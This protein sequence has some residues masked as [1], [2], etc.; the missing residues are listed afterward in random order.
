MTSLTIFTWG[1]EGWG[2]STP[3]LKKAMDAVELA[4]GHSPPYFVDLRIM[5]SVRATG[6]REAAFERTVGKDRYKWMRSL[7]NKR[8]LTGP[9][10]G[11]RH[12]I[13]D[14]AAVEELLGISLARAAKRQR[15]I[16]FCSCG[17]AGPPG[18]LSCHR[19][20]V[21]TLLLKTAVKR[22]VS[23]T[24][25]E[26]PGGEPKSVSIEISD[27]EA[28]K[29]MAGV[30]NL[31]LG[32]RQP[33]VDLLRLPWGSIVRFRTSNLSFRAL[34]DPPVYRGGKWLL[35]LPFGLASKHVDVQTLRK[36]TVRGR[37][38]DG[39]NARRSHSL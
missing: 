11:P 39:L 25:V 30:R 8:V 18:G 7:G 5:R 26:W 6:F 22:N 24:I 12:Q 9:R 27:L 29:L 20:T 36:Q 17:R 23:L 21:A 35:P 37:R 13:N 3:Q 10:P 28:K 33:S 31:I 1:Y 32:V 34:A 16:I 2:S 4:R 15:L 14:P 19:V 38:L